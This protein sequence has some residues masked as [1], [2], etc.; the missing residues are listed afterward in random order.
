MVWEWELHHRFQPEAGVVR[1]VIDPAVSQAPNA[2][3]ESKLAA[4]SRGRTALE[5]FRRGRRL[6]AVIRVG[7][8]GLSAEGRAR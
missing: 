6:P 8:D 4:V 5:A 1:V 7:V 3:S 2:A